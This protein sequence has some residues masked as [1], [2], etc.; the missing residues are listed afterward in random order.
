MPAGQVMFEPAPGP[1]FQ[2][3]LI[4]ARCE[5]NTKVVPLPSARRTAPMG[6]AGA[7]GFSLAITGSFH[8]VTLPRKIPTSASRVSLSGDLSSGRLYPITMDPAVAGMSCT[9]LETLAMSSS[10]I[11]LSL[12]PKS[13]VPSRTLLTPALLPSP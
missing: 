6:V 5:L 2:S 10:F 12:A 3:S 1:F 9:P 7:P 11:A 4:A 8:L 13:T